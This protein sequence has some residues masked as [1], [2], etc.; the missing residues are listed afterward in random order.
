MDSWLTDEVKQLLSQP[1]LTISSVIARRLNNR[2]KGSKQNIDERA[3]TEY[4]VDALDTSSL[5]NVW[6]SVIGLLRDQNIYLNTNIRKSTKENKTGADIGLIIKR[7]INQNNS[8]SEIEYSCLIQCK[9]VDVNGQI[10]DFY[11]EVGLE[12]KTQSSLMLDI[13]PSSF[14][15]I[16]TPSCLLDIDYSLIPTAFI[17]T[18]KECSSPIW[19]MGHFGCDEIWFPLLSDSQI[20]SISGVLVVPALAVEAQI[21]KSKD[22]KLEDILPNCMPLWYW[23]SEILVAGFAGDRRQDV[24][25]IAAN[26][27]K[28]S[29]EINIGNG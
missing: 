24:I 6:G 22:A 17:D 23:F 16:F 11:H 5:E 26:S 10:D 9:R 12:K 8:R 15:F 18:G 13:T 7:R 21:N 3:F 14:Y 1:C 28:F 25:N 19:D 29:I 20:D 2:I 4:L 27:V